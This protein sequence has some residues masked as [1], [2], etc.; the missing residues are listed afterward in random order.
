MTYTISEVISWP[1]MVFLT[2]KTSLKRRM[3]F[4]NYAFCSQAQNYRAVGDQSEL[5]SQTTLDR[6]GSQREGG[7][8]M[9]WLTVESVSKYNLSDL[10]IRRQLTSY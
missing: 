8:G 7:Q 2:Y 10:T 3:I 5:V 6:K 4:A 9:D 1:V